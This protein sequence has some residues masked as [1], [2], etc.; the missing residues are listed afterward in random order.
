M[1]PGSSVMYWL[2]CDTIFATLKIMVRVLPVCMR[3]PF[4][5]SHMS[6]FCGSVISSVVTS[7]G[8]IGPAVSKPLPLSHCAGG[9]LERAL[10][11]VVDDAIA[12][13]VAERLGL[14]HV[15]GLGA[16]H[17]AELDLPVELGRALGW[18][19]SSFGPLMQVV[20]FM[21]TIGSAGSAGRPPSAW[22]E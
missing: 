4:T 17:D 11:D 9:H 16:D 19:T 14:A 3:S 7:H 10:G 20:A 6:R 15:L 5:S 22:S 12:R 2:T 1:S 8:P 18:I 21:K 13:D